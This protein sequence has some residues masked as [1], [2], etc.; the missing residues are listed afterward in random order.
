M[1]ERPAQTLDLAAGAAAQV[2]HMAGDLKTGYFLCAKPKNQFIARLIG[3]VVAVLPDGNCTYM[4]PSVAVTSPRALKILEI[5]ALF[6]W[7]PQFPTA[8]GTIL[9]LSL[10][11]AAHVA[12]NTSVSLLLKQP[13]PQRIHNVRSALSGPK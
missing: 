2:S 4:A 7:L 3:S 6:G 11:P 12:P 8:L 13:H 9:K 1:P 5:D 10:K